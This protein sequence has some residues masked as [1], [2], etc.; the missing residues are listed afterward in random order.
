M[1][2]NTAHRQTPCPIWVWL[3]LLAGL[4]LLFL[5][6]NH[7]TSKK[8]LW[9]QQDINERTTQNMRDQADLSGVL[10]TTD[11]RDINL[12]GEVSSNEALKH[13]EQIAK[14]TAGVRM[15]M[16]QI[17]VADAATETK[18][19]ETL[20]A[21]AEQSG[22]PKP[23][24]FLAKVEAMPEEFSPLEEAENNRVDD[25]HA[26]SEKQT[27]SS[28]QTQAAQEKLKQLDFSNITFEKNSS[29]L[30]ESAKST[31][32]HVASTLK[33]NPA[34]NI[35]VDGHTD[36]SGRPELNLKISQQR[37][38]SVL[39]YLIDA[40]IDESRI[41]ANGF[42]DQFPIAPNDTKAGRIKNRRIEIKVE[43]GE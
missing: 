6:Y 3:V 42:G 33:D 8:A 20:T 38:Q 7:A 26:P 22:A 5:V 14:S 43:N 2:D 15:V 28:S 19:D 12:S 32:A 30:T 41:N 23:V 9:I 21:S 25:E 29:T 11:G 34:V 35:R 27:I 10:I 4:V 16:N 39:D 18:K 1:S 40:G 37:A 36:S 31:L 17:T 13:A 24:E